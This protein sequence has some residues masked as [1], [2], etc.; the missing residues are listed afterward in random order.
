[1]DFD[2]G[3]EDLDLC[4]LSS[5]EEWCLEDLEDFFEGLDLE[6]FFEGW[7]EEGAK[8]FIFEGAGAWWVRAG[9]IYTYI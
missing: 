6:D 5:L 2:T 4:R 8:E 9:V 3:E 7:E 1:M